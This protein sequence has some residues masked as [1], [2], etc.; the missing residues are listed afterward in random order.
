[1]AFCL[2]GSGEFEHKFF[3]NSNAQGVAYPGMLKLQFDW[4]IGQTAL[5]LTPTVRLREVTSL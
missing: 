5:G 3:K 4:Y 2:A 1:M